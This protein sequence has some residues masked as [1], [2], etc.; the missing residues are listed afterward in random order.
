MAPKITNPRKQF[1]FT[2]DIISPDHGFLEPYLVQEVIH[3][4]VTIEQDT[5]GDV[6]Y[7]IKTAGKV[8]VG[9]GTINKIMRASTPDNFLWD[10]L[11]SCQWAGEGGY[12]PKDYKK[13]LIIREFNEG[14]DGGI[15]NTW[16]WIGCWP[17]KLTGQTNNRTETG[18]TI[19]SV[20]F[21]IDR[22]EK[23]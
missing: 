9:N 16:T 7:D 14:A 12:V 21:S 15:I 18:N 23:I 2:V 10:W 8:S 19:E 13:N 11:N 17:T 1:R 20:E 3:P 4:E 22:V 6:N 5:H